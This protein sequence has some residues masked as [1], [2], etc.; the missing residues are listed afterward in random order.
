MIIGNG[1]PITEPLLCESWD[2]ICISFAYLINLRFKG[3]GDLQRRMKT[4][5]LFL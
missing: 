2:F 3:L 1:M 4:S 5:N